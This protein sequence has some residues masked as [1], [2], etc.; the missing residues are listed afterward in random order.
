MT[1]VSFHHGAYG[2]GLGPDLDLD[3]SGTPVD[4]LEARNVNV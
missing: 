3:H 2:G 4:L 1:S